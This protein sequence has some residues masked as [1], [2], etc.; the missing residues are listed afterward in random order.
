MA[1]EG[2][3][4]LI[5]SM[6]AT[7][8][9]EDLDERR[10]GM[11]ALGG[12]VALPDGVLVEPVDAGGVPAERVAAPGA[13][14]GR[15]IQYAHGGAY[16][17]GSVISHRP[18]CALLSAK[19]G[20]TV[21]DVDYRLAPE[22]PFPAAVDDAVAAYGW[23]TGA[24]E[25]DPRHVVLAGDSAGGGLALATL[26]ALR[27]AGRP[28]PAGAALLSP[29]ADLTMTAETYRTRAEV[30]PI[31][32]AEALSWSADAYLAGTAADHPLASPGRAD[33]RGLPPLLVHVGDLEVLLDDARL[34]AERARAA[35]VEVT[36]AEVPEVIH[37]WHLFAG[38]A[39]ESDEAVDEL[40]T[41]IHARLAG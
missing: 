5:E 21:L 41:W 7:P 35:G 31:C 11:D 2:M 19:T 27:D 36:F 34:V 20:A 16:T 17:A 12:A 23:L 38:F 14:P 25:V 37:V 39:P 40:A 8:L 4:F 9:A 32:N 24:E 30:D 29:W 33:L 13:D 1:S 15:W 28:L 10:A 3:Q 26:V 22:H 18:F 6:R